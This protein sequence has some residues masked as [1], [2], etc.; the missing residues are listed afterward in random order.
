MSDQDT[1]HLELLL[2]A[3]HLRFQIV[4]TAL[5]LGLTLASL[6]KT[7]DSIG[8]LDQAKWASENA[9]RVYQE[10]QDCLP[11]TQLNNED[12]QW[13]QETLQQLQLAI[14]LP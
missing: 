3:K 2:N 9:K 11:N 8:N 5:T 4:R 6:A 1:R 14:D 13:V 10:V 7:E 12:R